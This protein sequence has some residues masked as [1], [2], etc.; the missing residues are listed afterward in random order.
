MKSL[1]STKLIASLEIDPYI[2]TGLVI[3]L[4]RSK[5]G[6]ATRLTVRTLRGRILMTVALNRSFRDAN[7][8]E[9]EDADAT[10]YFLHRDDRQPTRT[11]SPSWLAI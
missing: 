3:L 5:S 4:Q 9:V 8:G 7:R 2:F 10:V 6:R 1:R 11:Q